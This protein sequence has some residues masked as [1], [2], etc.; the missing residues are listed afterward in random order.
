M[1]GFGDAVAKFEQKT[2]DR[3]ELFT[4][5]L[6]IEAFTRVIMRS[7]VDTGRFR[8]NWQVAIDNIPEGTLE[9]DDANGTATV[10]AATAAAAGVRLG[11]VIYLINNLPYA[12]RLE[13][14]WSGQ[15][16]AG[17]VGITVEELQP[18]IN[19]VLPQILAARP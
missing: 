12:Q 10:S 2:R 15:A 16:P 18:I 6:A 1:A 3:L 4:R 13:N 9:I 11:D 17:M 7:P 8:G 5:R 19:K 14:G